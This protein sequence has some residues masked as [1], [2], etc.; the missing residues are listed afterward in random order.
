VVD[1]LVNNDA[2]LDIL[3]VSFDEEA[4]AVR[5]DAP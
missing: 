1:R 3:V 2:G 4:A 5:E